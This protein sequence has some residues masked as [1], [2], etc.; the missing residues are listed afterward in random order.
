MAK[1]NIK[2][3]NCN[4]LASS[5]SVIFT[6]LYLTVEFYIRIT[7]VKWLTISFLTRL[8]SWIPVKTGEFFTTFIVSSNALSCHWYRLTYS[9]S[10]AVAFAGI[11]WRITAPW[12]VLIFTSNIGK[13]DGW[14]SFIKTF[15][16]DIILFTIVYRGTVCQICIWNILKFTIRYLVTI[17]LIT[18]W[19]ACLYVLACIVT[20][21]TFKVIKRTIYTKIFVCN[22]RATC[23]NYTTSRVLPYTGSSSCLTI[24][25]IL[26]AWAC[27][28]GIGKLWKYWEK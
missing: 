9:F 2:L 22:F 21:K 18:I 4:R 24:D 11:S 5:S 27:S 20:P 17:I 14:F 6:H 15:S 13:W 26:R 25:L 8:S 7:I 19:G 16:Y 1:I 12:G 23:G 28:T 3:I 10:W